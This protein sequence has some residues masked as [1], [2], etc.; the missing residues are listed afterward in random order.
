[1]HNNHSKIFISSNIFRNTYR[2]RCS[3]AMIIATWLT[4]PSFA[5]AQTTTIYHPESRNLQHSLILDILHLAIRKSG[6]GHLYVFETQTLTSEAEQI[7][8]I[9]NGN[10]SVIWAGAQQQ[11]DKL[12]TPIRI[13]ILKGLLGHRIFIIREDNQRVF[14]A[15]QTLEELKDLRPGQARFTQDTAILK[16]ANMKVVDPVKHESLFKMLEGGRFDY[17]PRS[18]HEPWTEVANHHDLPLAIEE[19]ILLVYPYAMYFFVAHENQALKNTIETGFRT[20]IDDGSFDQLFFDHELV[21][22]AFEK[23]NFKS[24]KIFRI[25]NPNISDSAYQ[26]DSALWLNVENM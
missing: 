4:S 20:A 10:L 24:R 9:R 2:F 3:L 19:R 14:D 17:F 16:H 18:V 15:V 12:L 25:K 8:Q 21:R 7:E 1:M 6:H 26:Q 13:P 11:T 22:N 23:S 5:Q